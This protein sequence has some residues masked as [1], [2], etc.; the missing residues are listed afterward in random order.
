MKVYRVEHEVNGHGPYLCGLGVWKEY[1][2]FDVPGLHE[3]HEHSL[4]H[5]GPWTDGDGQLGLERTSAHVFGFPSRAACD[6]WFES[7]EIKMRTL[8]YVVNV[9]ECSPE[10]VCVSPTEKQLI[11]IKKNAKLVD[12][13]SVIG[14]SKYY[15]T[16]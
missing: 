15:Q 4:E 9:Y 6:R 8:G 10:D 7:F 13:Q 5:P 3:A 2:K 16:N 1:E 12:T 14:Y 11:F